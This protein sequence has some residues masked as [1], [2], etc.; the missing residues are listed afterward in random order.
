M[1]FHSRLQAQ[2][3]EIK[4]PVWL[5]LRIPTYGNVEIARH[6]QTTGDFNFITEVNY[7]AYV[8]ATDDQSANESGQSSQLRHEARRL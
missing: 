6:E 2:L 5:P 1:A 3:D 4:R 7:S 8:F